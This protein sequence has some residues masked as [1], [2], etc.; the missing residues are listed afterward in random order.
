MLGLLAEAVYDQKLDPV[1]R[2]ATATVGMAVAL[3]KDYLAFR[4]TAELVVVT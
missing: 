1:M 2:L 3:S 4:I